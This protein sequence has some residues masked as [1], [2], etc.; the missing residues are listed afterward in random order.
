MQR[1]A[2]RQAPVNA[3]GIKKRLRQNHIG[4]IKIRTIIIHSPL[5]FG[6]VQIFS[7][8]ICPLKTSNGNGGYRCMI[9]VAGLRYEKELQRS[10][11]IAVCMSYVTI[12]N[13]SFGRSHFVFPRL[14]LFFL[15]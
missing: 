1:I 3:S 5:E 7:C 9:G 4:Q 11:D 2:N 8:G 13:S 14:P 10:G 12:Y 6:I 15:K